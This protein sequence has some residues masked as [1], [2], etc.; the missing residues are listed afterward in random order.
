[1][2]DKKLLSRLHGCVY[3]YILYVIDFQVFFLSEISHIAEKPS[4]IAVNCSKLPFFLLFISI[5]EQNSLS[6]SS[7]LDMSAKTQLVQK[8]KNQLLALVW[9]CLQSFASKVTLIVKYMC[10]CAINTIQ[11]HFILY[12]LLF[13][14][15]IL[16]ETSLSVLVLVFL[17]FLRNCTLCKT[18][19]KL[20]SLS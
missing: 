1:M 20:T 2:S 5:R 6:K 13:L 18:L 11:F 4:S 8:K 15:F 3:E 19:G 12:K 16:I 14:L 7:V 17:S 9:V 10:T